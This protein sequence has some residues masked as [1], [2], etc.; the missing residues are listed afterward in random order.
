MSGSGGVRYWARHQGTADK[1]HG[2][3][4]RVTGS[5]SHTGK[6]GVY[7]EATPKK[8]KVLLCGNTRYTLLNEGS[9]V[10]TGPAPEFQG[11][12]SESRSDRANESEEL[13]ALITVLATVVRNLS[14]DENTVMQKLFDRVRDLNGNDNN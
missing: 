5:R 4:I 2:R 6:V 8:H 11:T 13:E 12:D 10:F 7:L 1:N 3:P 9:F 14:L